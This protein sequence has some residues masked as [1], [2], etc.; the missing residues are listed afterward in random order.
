[1]A[2]ATINDYITA[3]R[4]LTASRFYNGFSPEQRQLVNAPQ[5]NYKRANP[6]LEPTVCSISGYSRPDDPK[7][8]GYIFSHLEHYGVDQCLEW[9]PTSKLAHRLLHAR[10]TDPRSWFDFVYR[11]YQHGAWFTFLVMSPTKVGRWS[12]DRIYPMGLPKQGEFWTDYAT[13]C[14]IDRELFKARDLRDPIRALWSFPEP[15]EQVAP[16]PLVIDPPARRRA[17]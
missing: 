9:L 8:A 15:L 6:H 12:Y 17:A 10:F 13:A 5:R 14:G 7:G 11:N 1:M 16:A 2:N 3:G 4:A